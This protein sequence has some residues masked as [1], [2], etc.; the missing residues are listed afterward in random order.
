MLQLARRIG[1]SVVIDLGGGVTCRV[2]F[3]GLN[4]WGGARLGLE[5]PLSVRIDRAEKRVRGTPAQL[6][7]GGQ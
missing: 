4:Q 1:E 5:A 7:E 2:T 6:R 3:L